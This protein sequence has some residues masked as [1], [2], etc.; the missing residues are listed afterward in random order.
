MEHSNKIGFY[1]MQLT[2]G[3]TNIIAT[4]HCGIPELMLLLTNG[5]QGLGV[6][7]IKIRQSF[8]ESYDCLIFMMEIHIPGQCCG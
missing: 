3:P 4:L 8:T 1:E 7:I 5:I 6:S 2:C